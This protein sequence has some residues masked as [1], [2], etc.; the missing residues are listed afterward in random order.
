MD[1]SAHRLALLLAVHRVGGIV[2]AAESQRLSPSAVSQQIK[3]LEKEVGTHVLDRTPSGSV[4]TEAGRILA[5]TAER[6]EDELTSARRELAEL[7]DST[8]TGRVRIG[9]FATAIR[10]LLLP[11]LDHAAVSHPG[12]HLTIEET[13][14]R[15]GLARLRRGELDLVLLERD[16][17]SL[18][19]APRAMADVPLLDE[20]W[21]IVVPPEQPAPSTLADLVRATWI[22]LDPNTA[23]AEALVRLSRQLGTPLTTHH[24][25]YD[26]DVVLAMVSFGLGYALLPELAVVSGQVPE[27]V[28]VVRLPGL[29]TRQL[30]VRHRATR[31]DPSSATRAVLDLLLAQAQAMELG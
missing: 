13:E 26:Y 10:A 8:P 20:S 11:M 2:A 7:D 12:L 16:V 23:G 6:I 15:A 28:S 17:H 21:L 31:T 1:L 14:E 19:T 30:V 22:D 24:V 29:G 25:G 5:D 4:L 3:L 18:T 9:S 27:G